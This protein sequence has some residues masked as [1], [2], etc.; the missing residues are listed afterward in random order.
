MACPYCIT[1]P[2]MPCSQC[3]RRAIRPAMPPAPPGFKYE[4]ARQPY[5][6]ALAEDMCNPC[7]EDTKI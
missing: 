6:D 4:D 5:W 3:G 2:E 7:L 1:E